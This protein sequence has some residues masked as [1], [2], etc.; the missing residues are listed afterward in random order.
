MNI[1]NQ[2]LVAIHCM[3]YNHEPYLRDCLEG[4]V[5]QKTKFPFVAI[6]HD[7]ASTDN[8]AAIIQEYA[9]K[10]PDIIKP[11]FETEN[12]YSKHDGSLDRIMNSA[13]DSYSPKYI[14]MCEG[15]D[16]WTDPYKL[17]KQVDFMEKH[18]DFSICF[19]KA[20]ILRQDT[21]TFE[22][23]NVK[24][25]PNITTIYDL[26]TENYLH[27]P[28]V[29]VRNI[30]SV[31]QEMQTLPQLPVGDYVYWM[32]TAR[33]GKIY[34]IQENTAIY[35]IHAG[36]IWSLKKHTTL[37]WIKVICGIYP[38]FPIEIQEILMK[39]LDTCLLDC[40][41]QIDSL[42]KEITNVRHSKAYRI[43]S[44]ILKPI[45]YLKYILHK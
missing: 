21:N 3:V 29:L 36:G 32:F 23:E 15:D 24:K 28:T 42:H 4:F 1:A 10:Y 19:T 5:M 18:K 8:S 34:K 13:I 38:Y 44:F 22:E 17:Q 37:K 6:V 12:Q 26:A 39:Q 41:N 7:D 20:I 43:G 35:R 2:Y 45:K 16:Y 27:T 40:S 30:P 33:F 14:A 31:R 9:D 11:I 25:V